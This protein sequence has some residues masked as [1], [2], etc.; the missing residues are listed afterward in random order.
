MAGLIGASTNIGFTSTFDQNVASLTMAKLIKDLVPDVKI[1]FRWR[2]FR[3]R[4]GVGIFFRAF[5]FIDYVVVGEERSR[6]RRWSTTYCWVERVPPERRHLPRRGEVRLE[7]N[8]AL[9]TGFSKPAR[10]TMTTTIT[11]WPSSAPKPPAD[12]TAFCLRRIPRL[13]VGREAPLHLCGLNAQSMKFRRNHRN[14]L[15]GDGI[16]LEPLYDTTRT[17]WWITSSTKYVDNCS[18]GSLPSIVI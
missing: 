4:N 3:R 6:S 12:W 11:S 10:L 5:P 8:T 1:V 15:R 2:Q 13:L 16:P 9:F 7:P 18:T 17:A 14:R